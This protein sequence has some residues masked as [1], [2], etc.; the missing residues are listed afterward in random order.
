MS[1]FNGTR[2]DRI[3][4][5]SSSRSPLRRGR[6]MA[7]CGLLVLLL[8]VGGWYWFRPDVSVQAIELA[9][10]NG[11]LVAA[12]AMAERYVQQSPDDL[13]GW[14]LQADLAELNKDFPKAAVAYSAVVQLR[15]DDIRI[16]HQYAKALLQSSQFQLAEDAYRAILDR[17]G[18]DEIAQT[19]I[20]WILF[21]QQRDRE[22]EDFLEACLKLEPGNSRLLFHL[23]VSSQ[24]PAN[25]LESL[26][27]LEKIDAD[28]PSQR[29]IELAVAECAW[30]M[31]DL[32][33]SR[34]LF[35]SIVQKHGL[36][37]SLALTLAEF[38]FEQ[39]RPEVAK[40]YLDWPLDDS[41]DVSNASQQQKDVWWWMKAQIA[42][43]QRQF[44]VALE[45]M[46][47][48]C[49]LR[50]RELRYIHARASL[51]QLL[52]RSQEA[53]A[54]QAEVAQRRIADRELSRLVNGGNLHQAD[55]SVLME[56][57]RHC[58]TLGRTFQADNWELLIRQHTQPLQ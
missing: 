7:G 34:G 13:R 40:K 46:T 32:R 27:L 16:R 29:S 26:P 50:P 31:G 24:K 33:R 10:K 22:L 47:E 43:S 5:T 1:D 51:L 58:R 38:E 35:N 57:A 19:E 30:R 12:K 8:T 56:I 48:A 42:Q 44:D 17:K 4:A 18:T 39:T 49:R 37:A 14:M 28:C 25:P 23:L 36:D 2:N 55:I 41:T 11:D 20:Q 52:G 9:M 6:L 45:A 21:H 53:T 54:L 15:P 3:P